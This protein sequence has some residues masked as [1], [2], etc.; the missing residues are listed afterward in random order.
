MRLTD[1]DRRLGARLAAPGALDAITVAHLT[2]SRARIQRALEAGLEV[3]R[4]PT[5]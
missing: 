5:P 2:E 1:L 4:R 3:D